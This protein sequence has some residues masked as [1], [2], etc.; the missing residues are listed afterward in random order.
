MSE[1]V[2]WT[3]SGCAPAQ[4]SQPATSTA[5]SPASSAAAKTRDS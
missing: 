2:T 5:G 4:S 3:R 1:S